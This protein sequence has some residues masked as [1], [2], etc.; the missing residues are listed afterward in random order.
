MTDS[1]LIQLSQSWQSFDLA[2]S[3]R[4]TIAQTLQQQAAAKE[5]SVAARKSL[6]ETVK[7][8]KKAVK[9]LADESKGNPLADAVL[10]N[11]KTATKAF[12][13]EIDNLTRR[14]KAAESA[15][16]SL[17]QPLL[18]LEDPCVVVPAGVQA[19]KDK[20]AQLEKE[21]TD[22]QKKSAV[23]TSASSS[24]S[25]KDHEELVSLRK[26]VAEYEVEFRSLK[27]QDITIR[28]LETR[29][30]ELQR[31]Q[32]VQLEEHIQKEH[33][34]VAAEHEQRS[35]QAVQ[36]KE[37][38]QRQLDAVQVQL[39]AERAGREATQEHYLEADQDGL[40]RQAA[41]DA[42]R[43]ILLADSER[44]REQCQVATRERDELRLKVSAMQGTSGGMSAPASGN[45]AKLEEFIMERTAYEAEVIGFFRC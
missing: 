6:Q 30:E 31:H 45:S 43:S 20:V 23:A 36:E 17:G 18:E 4:P 21:L 26:E 27:N 15:Y 38:L 9:S 25:R 29:I 14:C 5:A 39:Q 41:W 22:A 16:V 1:S 37:A 11:A 28:K 34:K 13:E 3:T 35:L 2:N 32:A 33:D 40:R 42:Q 7:S 44:L 12:Q 19:W 24:L 8:F 10:Q